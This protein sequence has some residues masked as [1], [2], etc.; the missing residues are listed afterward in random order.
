MDY[1]IQW[2]WDKFHGDVY[3]QKVILYSLI[4]GSGIL[5]VGWDSENNIPQLEAIEPFYFFPNPECRDS[6]DMEWCIIRNFISKDKFKAMTGSES[7]AD[8][9]TD[10]YVVNKDSYDPFGVMNSADDLVEVFEYYDK[11]E[12]V[13]FTKSKIIKR[14]KNMIGKIPIIVLHNYVPDNGF[15]GMSEIDQI[16]QFIKDMT[17]FR[18]NRHTNIELSSNIMWQIDP[19]KE[20]FIEDLVSAPGQV[21]RAEDGALK[22]IVPPPLNQ[23]TI[24]E[25]TILKNDIRETSGISDYLRGGTPQRFETATAIENLVSSGNARINMRVINLVEFFIKPLGDLLVDLNKSFLQP[26]YITIKT[27]TGYDNIKIDYEILKMID[28]D[29]DIIIIPNNIDRTRKEEFIQMLQIVMSNPAFG[30]IVNIKQLFKYLF[31][32]W[33]IPVY[34]LFNENP[35]P[36]ALPQQMPIE[37]GQMQGGQQPDMSALINM[38]GGMNAGQ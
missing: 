14:A 29:Y 35:Q 8:V 18:A 31:K 34:G 26:T 23:A 37:Q 24:N 33:N 13:L 30:Q 5:R 27:D 6:F 10:S 38:M 7:N 21:I 2:Q 28:S 19:N 12:I 22:P 36:Q 17:D 15:W 20:V 1:I 11:K 32:M 9:N 16:E 4:Y 25:D 3:L